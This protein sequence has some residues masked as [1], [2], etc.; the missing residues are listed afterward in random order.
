MINWRLQ[1]ELRKTDDVIQGLP[2]NNL[3]SR[4]ILT[5]YMD[6]PNMKAY[7]IL[8]KNKTD[9]TDFFD[10]F[11]TFISGKDIHGRISIHSCNHA[12][13]EPGKEDCSNLDYKTLIF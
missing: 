11:K 3:L 6:V 13:N 8:F 1:L 12:D 4:I 7:D 10:K 5:E 9:M 2:K